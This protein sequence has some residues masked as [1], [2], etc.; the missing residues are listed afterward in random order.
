MSNLLCFSFCRRNFNTEQ[1]KVNLLKVSATS[2]PGSAASGYV[3]SPE[4]QVIQPRYNKHF[5]SFMHFFTW[6]SFNFSHFLWSSLSQ[7]PVVLQ[8]P[9]AYYFPFIFFCYW[10]MLCSCGFDQIFISISLCVG[11]LQEIWLEV[12]QFNFYISKF[13]VAIFR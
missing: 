1:S 9:T 10:L 8:T 12:S 7:H 4:P 2:P 6:F 3:R 5:C 11:G 13:F